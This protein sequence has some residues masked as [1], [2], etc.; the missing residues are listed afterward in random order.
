M[1]YPGRISS[2]LFFPGCNLRCPWCHNG[3]LAT[4]RIDSEAAVTLEKA[5]LHLRRRKT[6]L[7]GVVLSGGEPCLYGGLPEIVAEIRGLGLPVKID[8]NGLFPDM[9]E[10]LISIEETRPNYIAMDLKLAPVRYVELLGEDFRGS[11]GGPGPDELEGALTR[12]AALI[13]A[14]GVAHE[15]RSLALPEGRITEEDFAAI[16]VLAGDSPLKI[17]PFR[18]GN[19]LDPSWNELRP[20]EELLKNPRGFNSHGAHGEHRED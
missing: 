10:K 19:C 6:L 9:L 18:P 8:T 15:F 17:R 13:R 11:R 7:G 12:S 2:V 3:D 14:S 4:G 20:N 16:A 5:I 1:D